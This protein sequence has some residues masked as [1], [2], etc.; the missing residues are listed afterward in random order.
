MA[1][2][3]AGALWLYRALVLL[4]IACP[5]ALVIATPVAYVSA[6]AAAAR[7]GVLIKGGIHLERLATIRAIAFD[8]TGTLTHGRPEV[9][10][11]LSV[12]DATPEA[13][14]QLAAAVERHSEH[15]IASAIV[16]RAL[17]TGVAPAPIAD[18]RASHGLG[19]EGSVN[20][21]RVLVGS[22]RY[23]GDRGVDVT[24]AER[25]LTTQAARGRTAAL[26]AVDSRVIGLVALADLP[27]GAARDV[28]ELLRA[29]GIPHLAVLTG[30]EVGAAR[31]V[32]EAVGIRDV[33]A[34]LLPSEK[35]DAVRRLRTEW[36]SV[37]MIGDGVNDAP[38]LAASD[39]GIAMG[40]VGSDAALETADVALMSD[41]LARLP[42][43]IRL[44]R[45]AVRT[46]RMNIALALVVKAAF[47]AM[48]VTGETS[49]WMAIVADTGTSLVV[50]ANG[51]RLLRIR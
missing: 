49:L 14:L 50:I 46:V 51:L 16:R 35:V 10:E 18:F 3:G 5:C 21:L 31:S 9:A 8:K 36:G 34:G 27:R 28:V 24:P 1:G 37:A 26:V 19:A 20:G 4:V 17:A 45:A 6:L 47:L 12:S 30:D 13:V 23:L 25:V 41:E 39:V 40:A 22:A 33:R 29:T 11:I 48:A 44:S 32:A 7:R 43:A 38:A 2:W 15:P 42:F